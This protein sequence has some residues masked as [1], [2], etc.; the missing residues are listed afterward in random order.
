M[1]KNPDINLTVKMPV[2]IVDFEPRIEHLELLREKIRR[3]HND[4][5]DAFRTGQIIEK[6]WNDYK[7]DV[8]GPRNEAVGVAICETR[9]EKKEA[10]RD[11]AVDDTKMTELVVADSF[12]NEVADLGS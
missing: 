4:T 11:L 9:N 12:V 6:E 2:E 1:A 3:E 7:S 5:G 10:A 8:F